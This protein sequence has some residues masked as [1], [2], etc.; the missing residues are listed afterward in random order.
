MAGDSALPSEVADDAA[1]DD[2][3]TWGKTVAV[4]VQLR[5]LERRVQELEKDLEDADVGARCRSCRSFGLQHEKTRGPYNGRM[6][7]ELW[8]CGTCGYRE[9]RIYA[10]AEG[11]ERL[12]A[13]DAR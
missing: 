11:P 4:A 3:G 8:C 13:S 7:E 9:S 2:A 5:S 1:A 6:M 12:S 10:A